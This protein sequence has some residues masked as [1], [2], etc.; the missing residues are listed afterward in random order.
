MPPMS[1]LKWVK[2]AAGMTYGVRLIPGLP[3]GRLTPRPSPTEATA[4][5]TP[6]VVFFISIPFLSWLHAPA[7][8]R[9][10]CAAP[11]KKRDNLPAPAPGVNHLLRRGRR[12][13]PQQPCTTTTWDE[14][15]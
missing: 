9:T 6:H 14:N 4:A 1:P 12:R 10:G 5:S 3:T 15:G 13:G 2:T 7:G 11:A 8:V